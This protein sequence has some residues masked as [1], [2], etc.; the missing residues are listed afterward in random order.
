MSEKTREQPRCRK[1]DWELAFP[2]PEGE[3][4]R[5]FERYYLTYKASQFLHCDR[6][7]RFAVR[8]T[9][10]K[11]RTLSRHEVGIYALPEKTLSWRE[12]LRIYRGTVNKWQAFF[13]AEDAQADAGQRGD[14][15]EAE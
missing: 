5:H 14:G 12:C 9:S 6:C 13:A 8:L 2:G 4:D 3:A 10:G 11:I 1:H 15:E 7:S